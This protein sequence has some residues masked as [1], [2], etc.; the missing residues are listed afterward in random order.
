MSAPAKSSAP[1]GLDTKEAAVRLNVVLDFPPQTSVIIATAA[2]T[3]GELKTQLLPLVGKAAP[4]AKDVKGSKKADVK[5]NWS[6]YGFVAVAFR[7]V[8]VDISDSKD[9]ADLKTIGLVDGT[10]LVVNAPV[11]IKPKRYRAGHSKKDKDEDDK[12]AT[13]PKRKGN[14]RSFEDYAGIT[15]KNVLGKWL[16]AE[17]GT[18]KKTLAWEFIEG[19]G[20]EVL[21]QKA[22]LDLKRDQV[23]AIFKSEKL[24][25]KKES[26]V[27]DA[28]VAWANAEN[29]R[30]PPTSTDEK[31][32]AGELIK[33]ALGN[34]LF[35]TIR[36][37]LLELNDVALKVSALGLLDQ[38]QTLA[39]FTF[40]GQK[41]SC[42]G[43]E[44][45]IEKLSI[46]SALKM[47][48][49]KPRKPRYL[50]D[51]NSWVLTNSA[52]YVS[53]GAFQ[54][55]QTKE[56]LTDLKNN[57]MTGATAT[58]NAG[59]AFIQATFPCDVPVRAI[60]L[61]PLHK[62]EG[63]WGAT[64]GTGAS[65]QWSKDNVQWN[66]IGTV[67]HQARQIQKIQCNGVIAARYWRLSYNGYIGL[68]RFVFE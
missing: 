26:D 57:F 36:F 55:E 22:F 45:K 24:N 52:P 48:N 4:D 49:H 40:L 43:D 68:S 37:P 44:K 23:T 13:K 31:K 11:S 25:V 61:A 33:Q 39:L 8:P 63:Y 54:A 3:F 18:K 12:D 51:L 14:E 27:L 64:N 47:F 30:N 10:T 62:N 41:A 59:A 58:N 1:G 29:K 19:K 38:N 32:S 66:T 17:A 65:V 16:A 34:D 35:N 20:S 42:A 56:A 21:T 50:V 5:M 6:N 9:T 15:P 28:A 2:T 7:K 53:G 46:D 67:A 60:S